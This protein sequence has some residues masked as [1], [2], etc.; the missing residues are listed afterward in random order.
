M[1]ARARAVNGL[2]EVRATLLRQPASPRRDTLLQA[3]VDPVISDVKWLLGE[4]ALPT[5]LAEGLLAGSMR[6]AD[7]RQLSAILSDPEIG[8]EVIAR[9][10]RDSVDLL[11]RAA[12]DGHLPPGRQVRLVSAILPEVGAARGT[13]LAANALAACIR[14]GFEGD[15][16][17]MLAM[18]L[19]AAGE[20]LDGPRTALTGLEG[21]LGAEIV[22]RNMLAFDRAPR[23]ARLRFV[24][25]V[26]EI[27]GAL[28]TR[29]AIGLDM[30]AAEACARLMLDAGTWRPARCLR[31]PGS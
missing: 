31:Q 1:I 17:G 24:S 21:G 22:S 5:E 7:I 6:N 23:P 2:K 15:Q 16:V 18:L 19:G 27:A 9:L 25:A 10:G 8:D 12:L 3:T 4:P 20:R 30:A 14:Q 29:R 26:E 11:E 28:A 13:T